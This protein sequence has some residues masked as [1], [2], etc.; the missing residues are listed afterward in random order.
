M[1]DGDKH[2]SGLKQLID[3]AMRNQDLV[4]SASQGKKLI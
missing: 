2:K 1:I 4:S 3:Q